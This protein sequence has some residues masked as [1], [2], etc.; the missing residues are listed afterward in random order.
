MYKAQFSLGD[1]L[2]RTLSA[3]LRDIRMSAEWSRMKIE[4]LFIN[5]ELSVGEFV[6]ALNKETILFQEVAA[7]TLKRDQYKLLFGLKPGETVILADPRIVKKVYG[8][9]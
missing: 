4:E 9:K 3:R 8:K 1:R 5:Q 6:N 2:D 7:N